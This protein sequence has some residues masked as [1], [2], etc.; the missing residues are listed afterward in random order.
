MFY[1]F[2][3]NNSGG[4]WAFDAAAGISFCVIVEAQSPDEANDKAERIGLY[5]DGVAH[6]EDCD[7]CGDRWYRIYEGDA[8]SLVPCL[9]STPVE[10][11]PVDEDIFSRKW[12]PKGQAE[13]FVHYADGH[14]AGFWEE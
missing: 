3:Q 6:H 5:F 13:V 12:M 7:C 11:L 1:Q 2:R 9:Y 4:K 10:R 14:F 8:G